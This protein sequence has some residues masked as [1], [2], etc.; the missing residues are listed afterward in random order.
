MHIWFAGISYGR[1]TTILH[2]LKLSTYVQEPLRLC[3][4][5]DPASGFIILAGVLLKLMVMVFF[6]FFLYCLNL[7]LSLVLSELL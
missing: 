6:V 5:K 7:G 4:K 1:F 2:K 3:M